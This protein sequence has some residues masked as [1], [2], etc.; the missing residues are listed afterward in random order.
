ML[1]P[2]VIQIIE[3]VAFGIVA[4]AVSVFVCMWVISKGK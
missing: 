2:L 1:I 4:G 3:G